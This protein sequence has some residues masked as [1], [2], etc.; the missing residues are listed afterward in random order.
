MWACVGKPLK[1]VVTAP[2]NFALLSACFSARPATTPTRQ[3]LGSSQMF[4]RPAA[5]KYASNGVPFET[6]RVPATA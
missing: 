2:T 4:Q 3:Y 6:P 5:V 1:V